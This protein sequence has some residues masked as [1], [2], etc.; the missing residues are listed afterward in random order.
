MTPPPIRIEV[1]AES[2][3]EA[4]RL[5]ADLHAQ[6]RGTS[7][8]MEVSRVKE[9][10]STMDSGAT[11]IAIAG[12]AAATALAKGIAD[13]LRRHR[14]ASIR[15]SAQGDVTASNVTPETA[16]EIVRALLARQK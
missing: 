15:V 16:L 3:A 12:T 4:N 13:W 10:P 2:P 7:E 9:N 14:S 1:E 5:T 11:L 6:L 8:D